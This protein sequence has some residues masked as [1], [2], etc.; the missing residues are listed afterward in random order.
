METNPEV[1]VSEKTLEL[2]MQLLQKDKSMLPEIMDLSECWTKYSSSSSPDTK[3]FYLSEALLSFVS[4]NSQPHFFETLIHRQYKS[5]PKTPIFTLSKIKALLK[6]SQPEAALRMF[7]ED[8]KSYEALEF[9]RDE[10]YERIYNKYLAPEE[11]APRVQY[12]PEILLERE[13]WMEEEMTRAHQVSP[14]DLQRV[15]QRYETIPI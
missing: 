9:K 3:N 8:S 7:E 1:K 15:K 4:S 6:D 11:T 10:F 14:L 12:H 2:I 5:E 13:K